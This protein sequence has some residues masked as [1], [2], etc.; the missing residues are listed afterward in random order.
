NCQ[1][2][3]NQAVGGA[4][5]TGGVGQGAGMSNRGAAVL[6]VTGSTFTG[7][8]ATAGSLNMAKGGGIFSE[9]DATLTVLDSAFVGNVATGSAN[10]APS[11][12]AF[13]GG[14]DNEGGA[15][16]RDTLFANNQAFG[17][18]GPSFGSAAG[19]GAIFNGSRE[20]GQGLRAILTVSHSTFT[21]NQALGGSGIIG[22]GAPPEGRPLA[23][24]AH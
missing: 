7:N 4:G 15:T 23:H 8:H 5:S 17:G 3:S 24:E 18:S 16:V 2:T 14:L 20:P 22:R 11:L 6:T 13:G 9:A 12:R 1:I 19:G 10:P 21:D